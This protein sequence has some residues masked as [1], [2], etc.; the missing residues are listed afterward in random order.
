MH[1]VRYTKHFVTGNLAG[2]DVRCEVSYPD[3]ET[4]LKM[5]EW[6]ERCTPENPGKDCVTNARF[7]I[8]F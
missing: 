4:A 5:L 7:W 6:A 3:A 1:T 8:S 2:L